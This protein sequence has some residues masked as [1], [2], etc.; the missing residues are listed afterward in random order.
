MMK[1]GRTHTTAP[2]EE[3]KNEIFMELLE[4][5]TWNDINTHITVADYTP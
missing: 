5:D 4:T 3:D 2:I 1:N